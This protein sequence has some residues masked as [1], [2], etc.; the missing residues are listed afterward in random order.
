MTSEPLLRVTDVGI[1]FGGL[2]AF[3]FQYGNQSR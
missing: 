1:Q 3:Q 2:K